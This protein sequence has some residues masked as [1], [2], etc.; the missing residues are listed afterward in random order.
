MKITYKDFAE[1]GFAIF[2][3]DLGSENSMTN[4]HVNLKRLGTARL[5]IEYDTASTNVSLVGLMFCQ[6]PQLITLDSNRRV[7]KDYFV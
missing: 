4:D 1:N 3:F 7:E 6:S 2:A 5:S